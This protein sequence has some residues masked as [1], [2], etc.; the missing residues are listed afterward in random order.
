MIKVTQEMFDKV[1]SKSQPG[2]A[3][4]KLAEELGVSRATISRIVSSETL[5]E[6]KKKGYHKNDKPK[7]AE[8]VSITVTDNKDSIMFTT[9]IGNRAKITIQPKLSLWGKICRRFWR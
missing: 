2:K 1:K 6:Y 5:D 7:R 8:Y 4:I 3:Q 9:V